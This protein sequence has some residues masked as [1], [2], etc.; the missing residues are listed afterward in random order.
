MRRVVVHKFIRIS[1]S[2][3]NYLHEKHPRRYLWIYY[4]IYF[5]LRVHFVLLIVSIMYHKLFR[6][7]CFASR[8]TSSTVKPFINADS[9]AEAVAI[10]I[11]PPFSFRWNLIWYLVVG[12]KKTKA[13]TG[14]VFLKWCKESTDSCESTVQ[15]PFKKSCAPKEASNWKNCKPNDQKLKMQMVSLGPNYLPT[16]CNNL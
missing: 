10:S 14:L 7:R 12:G 9:D 3:L 6:N 8:A 4:L 11:F 15:F 16:T 1:P 13:Y 5:C 2:C